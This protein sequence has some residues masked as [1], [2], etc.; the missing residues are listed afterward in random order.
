MARDRT[1]RTEAQQQAAAMGQYR[2]AHLQ[3]LD[4]NGSVHSETG[5]DALHDGRQ[6][7][8]DR[9]ALDAEL[10]RLRRAA[11]GRCGPSQM[12]RWVMHV[13]SAPRSG[14]GRAS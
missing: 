13:C 8:L 11:G 6:E 3:G 1:T 10:D 12:P 2:C 14:P 9:E 5:L 4:S 7:Q